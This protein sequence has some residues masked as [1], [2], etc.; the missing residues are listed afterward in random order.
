MP[1]SISI[2]DQ[3]HEAKSRH[4]QFVLLFRTGDFY[5]ALEEDA[6][7]LVK[8]LKVEPYKRGKEVRVAGFAHRHLEANLRKLFAAG[9]RVAICEQVTE[10]PENTKVKQVRVGPSMAG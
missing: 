10:A 9:H 6:D 7:I 3:F 1:K 8:V 2:V 4:P 5:E